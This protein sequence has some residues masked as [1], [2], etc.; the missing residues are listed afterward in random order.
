MVFAGIWNTEILK[1]SEI[2]HQCNIF[3]QEFSL[4]FIANIRELISK[5]KLYNLIP[6]FWSRFIFID[7][8][9]RMA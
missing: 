2:Q 4:E 7:M 8:C 9:R 6:L 5:I 1:F 3:F